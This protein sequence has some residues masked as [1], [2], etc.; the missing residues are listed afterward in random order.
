MSD[1]NPQLASSVP[2]ACRIPAVAIFIVIVVEAALHVDFGQPFVGYGLGGAFLLLLAARPGFSRIAAACCIAIP[3]GAAAVWGHF[4]GIPTLLVQ[5][6]G[7]LGL[8]SL[9]VVSCLVAWRGRQAEHAAYRALLPSAVLTFLV[10]GAV[11]S[12][13]MA[14][15]IHPKTFDL[16]A[17]AFDGCLGFQPSFLLGGFLNSAPWL[18]P[19]VKI[20]YEGIVLAMA[21]LYAA[22][23]SRRQKPIW[24]LIEILFAAAMIGYLFFSV[25]PVCGPRYAFVGSFPNASLPYA[26]LHHLALERIPVAPRFPRNGVPSLHMTWALLIWWNT[27]SLP[28]WM[29]ASA[30][31][32]VITTVF[33][34]L[35]TGEH[36]VFDLVVALP[37]SLWMQASMAHTVSFKRRERWL[38]AVCGCALFLMWLVIGR[39]GFRWMLLDPLLTW[40]LVIG[41]SVVS[42]TWAARLPAMIPEMRRPEPPTPNFVTAASAG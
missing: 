19:L 3:L 21:A 42:L 20:T 16:Y 39:Y 14:S 17:Y 29:R 7:A 12:L 27:R 9:L 40:L 23:M 6:M 18:F 30:L 28:R 11:Y 41:S 24:E 26:A 32:L 34:T 8:A 31:A 15:L 25:F 5:A 38:P 4:Q 37:F 1:E 33:D 36:Y 13:N 35:A 2:I 22:F 10:I